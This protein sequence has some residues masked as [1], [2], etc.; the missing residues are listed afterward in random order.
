MKRHSP[1]LVLCLA[2][3]WS[4]CTGQFGSAI[5]NLKLYPQLAPNA[6]DAN[7]VQDKI[8]QLEIAQERDIQQRAGGAHEDH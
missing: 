7:T 2:F 5:P 6:A 8:S 3:L 1:L 4:G